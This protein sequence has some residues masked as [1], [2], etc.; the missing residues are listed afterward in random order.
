VFTDL[1]QRGRKQ[2]AMRLAST[3]FWIVLI[4]LGALTGLGMLLVGVILPAFTG[5]NFDGSLAATLTQIMFPVVLLLGLT[6]VI[7][8]VLQSYDNFGIAAL[9]PAAWNF[10]ILGLLI[11]LHHSFGHGSKGAVTAYA[12]AWLVGTVVQ[13]LIIAW[14]LRRIDFHFSF[15]LDWRDPKIARIF[16]LMLPITLG[17]GIINLDAL[18]NSTMGALVQTPIAGA[19]PR[20]IQLAFLLYMLP[21]GVFSVAVSTVLFPTLSRQAARRAPREMRHS[22]GNGLRQINLLLIPSAAGMMVLAHPIVQLVFQH[23]RFNA[24][25]TELTAKALFWFCWS[26]PFAG[27]NLLMTR[28]FF[29]LQRPWLPTKLAAINMVV[30]IIVSVALY[31]PLGIAGLVIGTATANIVMAYI[32]FRR[33]RIGFNGH[34]EGAET[35]MIS[36]RILIAAVAMAAIARVVWMLANS[37]VGDS[38]IGLVFSVG[39]AVAVAGGFYVW[40]ISHMRVPE[41]QQIESM[42]MRRLRPR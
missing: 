25:N 37:V 30:D 13:L 36:A 7:T 42:L 22:L 32:Q 39:I 5:Q 19:G 11:A 26:L 10:V 9:A 17:L 28:T 41:W 20:S 38:T 3:L 24:I 40:A 14:A 6:S 29:A 34:L 12:V 15:H 18:I 27:L 23:G 4:V 33:L 1:L 8:G 16:K 21:Q 35:L 2:E 31:K